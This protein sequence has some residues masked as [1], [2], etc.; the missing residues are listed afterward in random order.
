MSP[1]KSTNHQHQ[2][3]HNGGK[4][5]SKASSHKAPSSP[6]MPP[7]VKAPLA[8]PV[9]KALAAPP[10]NDNDGGPVT[11]AAATYN[12]LDFGAKGDGSSDDTK[13]SRLK[14]LA[15]GTLLSLSCS[16]IGRRRLH[17]C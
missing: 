1:G 12:V 10:E 5:K 9:G 15:V 11:D 7:K 6:L 4:S 13:L 3:H 8:P 17:T 2:H 14:F 16:E